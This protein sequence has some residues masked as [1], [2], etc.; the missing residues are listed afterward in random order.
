MTMPDLNAYLTF[1]GN[2]TE[3]M[4]FFEQTLGGKL[5]L[6]THG[7]SPI[8]DQIPTALALPGSSTAR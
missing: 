1:N 2:C 6:M 3:A 7:Q 5:D 4:R 8:A